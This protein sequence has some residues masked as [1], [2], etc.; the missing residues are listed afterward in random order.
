MCSSTLHTHICCA[1]S[2]RS[3]QPTPDIP[4]SVDSVDSPRCCWCQW[5]KKLAS[6][7][8]R[9]R[10]STTWLPPHRAHYEDG[11]ARAG[12]AVQIREPACQ[13]QRTHRKRAR[14]GLR[15]D[16]ALQALGLEADCGASRRTVVCPAPEVNE[17]C[18]AA[19]RG[20]ARHATAYSAVVPAT[21]PHL[22]GWMGACRTAQ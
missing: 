11:D 22:H 5:A 7:C 14:S 17:A 20:T 9:N 21:P 10:G 19:Q 13:R 8:K 15:Q 18:A 2:Y 1:P 3:A 16:T 12:Q 6:A 4:Y